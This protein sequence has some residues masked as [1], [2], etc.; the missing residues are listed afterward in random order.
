M[1]GLI[2]EDSVKRA[3]RAGAATVLGVV[4]TSYGRS[5]RLPTV[6]A[7]SRSCVQLGGT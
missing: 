1:K 3:E 7:T 6:A 5:E 4:L 2:Q